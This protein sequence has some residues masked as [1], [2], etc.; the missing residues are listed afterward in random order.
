[1]SPP[2]IPY[3]TSRYLGHTVHLDELANLNDKDLNLLDT[4]AHGLHEDCSRSIKADDIRQEDHGLVEKLL[5]TSGRFLYAIEQEKARRQRQTSIL[6]ILNQLAEVRA[7][8]DTLK[9]Q[10]REV[11]S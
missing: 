4:E 9:A 7:E 8:C 2:R 3:I 6:S 11:V 10:L 1:M 5:R